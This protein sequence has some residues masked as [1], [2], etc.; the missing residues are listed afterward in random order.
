MATGFLMKKLSYLVDSTSAPVAGIAVLSTWIGYEIGLIRE[1]SG[2]SPRNR[3]NQLYGVFSINTA[4]PLFT[5]YSHY[6]CTAGG[7][8]PSRLWPD[9]AGRANERAAKAAVLA[10]NVT[11]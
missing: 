2:G 8:E 7:P 11:V 3:R 1:S 6:S 4:I 9:A 10:D 5:A